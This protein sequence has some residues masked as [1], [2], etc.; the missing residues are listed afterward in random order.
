MISILKDLSHSD[1]HS[2]VRVAKGYIEP[3]DFRVGGELRP[4]QSER[5]INMIVEDKFLSRVTVERMSRNDK[6]VE[7]FDI[8]PRQLKRVPEGREPTEQELS[9]VKEHGCILH[10]KPVNLFVNIKLTTLRNN[11][12]KPGLVTMLNQSFNTVFQN[13]LTDLGFVGKG[14]DGSDFE[15]LHKGWLKIAE[16]SSDAPKVEIQPSSVSWIDKLAAIKKASDK[17]Y[18]PTSVFIMSP[19]DIMEYD[20][21]LG[22]MITGAPIIADEAGH[23]FL[24]QPTVASNYMPDGHVL[25][26]PIKNLILGVNKLIRRSGQWHAMRRCFEFVYDM[27]VDYEIYIKKACVLATPS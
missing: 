13:D 7:V 10:A 5:V 12:D 19:N 18:R 1:E 4:E 21:Q 26:T 27:S 14:E 3:Q 17:L 16:E 24:R 9:G 22:K 8:K 2:L 20:V 25:Y 11:A 6:D 15:N 23:R